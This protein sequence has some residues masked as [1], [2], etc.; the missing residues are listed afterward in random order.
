MFEG[1]IDELVDLGDVRLRYGSAAR[2]H[3]YC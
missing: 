2:D 1:F 3:L